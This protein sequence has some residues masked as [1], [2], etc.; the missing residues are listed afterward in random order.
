MKITKSKLKQIIKE[1]LAEMIDL[2]MVNPENPD[3]PRD[4]SPEEYD[5]YMGR[6]KKPTGNFTPDQLD[7]LHGAISSKI[8]G[9]KRHG[10]YGDDDDIA[11]LEDLLDTIEGTYPEGEGLGEAKNLNEEMYDHHRDERRMDYDKTDRMRDYGYADGNKGKSPNP[12]D[13]RNATYRQFFNK[14]RE[15]AGLVPLEWSV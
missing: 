4:V 7:Y 3:E 12:N 8:Y 14:G 1:E 9:M 15:D 13:V 11:F 2:P 6:E 5:E 10:E